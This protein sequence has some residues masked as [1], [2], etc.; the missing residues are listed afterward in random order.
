MIVTQLIGGLGNQLFQYAIGRHLAMINM[1]ELRLDLSEFATYE[2]H[3]YSLDHLNVRARPASPEDIAPLRVVREERYFHFDPGFRDYGDGVYL[4]GYWQTE[5]YFAAIADVIRID[6]QVRH[7]IAGRSLKLATEMAESNSVSVHVR[8]GDYTPNT[9]TDQVLEALDLDYYARA[10]RALA[11][12]E[13]GLR[14]FVFSDDHAWVKENLQLGHPTVYVDHNAADR[15]YDDLRLM[16]RCRHNIIA[17][18]SF[19]WWGAWL[20]PNPGKRVFAPRQW[21]SANARTL[22]ARDIIPMSWTRI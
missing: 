19:S 21:L 18:S 6:L 12:D 22:V 10:L 3:A 14:C 7:P 5:Q 2:L 16:S 15:N 9:Y 11:Q 1:A 20:N 17:N 8:R 4:K 13:R